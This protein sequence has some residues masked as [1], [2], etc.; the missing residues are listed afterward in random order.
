MK[1]KFFLFA[2]MIS[3]M[4]QGCT[5]SDRNPN[6]Y[7][8]DEKGADTS[9][10]ISG[11]MPDSSGTADTAQNPTHLDENNDQRGTRIKAAPDSAGQKR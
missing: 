9:G 5:S 8:E 7:G 4:V 11:L 6:G 2:V 3:F 10:S 1:I